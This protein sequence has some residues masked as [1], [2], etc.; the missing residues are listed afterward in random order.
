M[1]MHQGV[2]DFV[3]Q[4]TP[5]ITSTSHLAFLGEKVALITEINNFFKMVILNMYRKKLFTVY[6]FTHN[7]YI[8]LKGNVIVTIHIT[9]TQLKIK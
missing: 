8:V 1:E 9:N 2:S 3:L 6:I 5:V 7:Y 4:M